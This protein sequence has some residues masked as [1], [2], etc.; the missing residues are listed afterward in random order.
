[1]E[2][3]EET[4]VDRFSEECPSELESLT[5]SPLPCWAGLPAEERSRLV[6]EID[7]TAPNK[8]VEGAAH[9]TV[10]DP[11][12]RQRRTS[13][14]PRPKAHASTKALWIE[15]VHRY[16]SFLAAFRQAS[17]QW[18]AGAL[19]VQFPAHCFHPPAWGMAP[20]IV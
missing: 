13:H 18:L 11:H 12:D 17:R 15:A 2:I 14:S 8:I 20:R 3:N 1:M 10:Q 16:Q 7:A 9:I 5:L 4:H 19:E 6:A